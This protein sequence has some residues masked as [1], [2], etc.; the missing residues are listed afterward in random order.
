MTK[1]IHMSLRR[2]AC[3]LHGARHRERDNRRDL[4]DLVSESLCATFRFVVH[5]CVQLNAMCDV[6]TTHRGRT[7]A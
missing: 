3:A 1:T 6:G 7:R 4:V 5:A 2:C